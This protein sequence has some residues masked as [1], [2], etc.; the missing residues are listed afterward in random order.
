MRRSV[1]GFCLA[2][3]AKFNRD[4]VKASNGEQKPLQGT[5][6]TSHALA[7][8]DS[9]NTEKDLEAAQNFLSFGIH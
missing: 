8:M 5:V 4:W 2:L 1:S 9:Y 7:I 6:G 3:A